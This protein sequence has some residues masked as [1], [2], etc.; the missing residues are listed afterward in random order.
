MYNY[1]GSIV[2][3]TTSTRPFVYFPKGDAVKTWFALGLED[4]VNFSAEKRLPGEDGS[5]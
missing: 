5:L 4:S 2:C 3:S 1:N